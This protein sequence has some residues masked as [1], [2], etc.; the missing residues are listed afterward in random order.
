MP[1]INIKMTPPASPEQKAEIIK[2]V[3]QVMVDVLGKNPANTHV[4]LE[5]IPTDDWGIAG[6]TVTSRR[7][8]G[9]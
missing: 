8:R 5:T 2:R 7:Q 9:L 3:T 1:F 4:V 6:E